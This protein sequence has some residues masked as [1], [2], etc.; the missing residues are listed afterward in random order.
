MEPISYVYTIPYVLHLAVLMILAYVELY[1]EQRMKQVVMQ[2]S[3]LSL[4]LFYGLRGYVGMDIFAYH[5]VFR[6]LPTLWDWNAEDFFAQSNYE[7]GLSSTWL[8]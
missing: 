7:I 1:E 6:D 2:L 4:V 8:C 5:A 3:V